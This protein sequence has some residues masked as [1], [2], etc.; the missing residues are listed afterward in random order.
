MSNP[1]RNRPPHTFWKAGVSDCAASG[2]DPVTDVPFTLAQN[3]AVATAGSCFAQ[4]ISR[5][6]VAQGFHY[7]VTE[8]YQG[9][10]GTVD[11]NYGVFPA[12]F[13]NL[14]TS[15]QLVQLFDRAYG[16]SQ[17]AVDWWQGKNQEFIDPFRPRI[18]AGGFATAELLLADREQHFAAV[19]AMFEQCQVFIFTLGLTETWM[20]PDGSALPLAPG[21]VANDSQDSAATFVNLGV[22]EIIADLDEFLAKFATVN[23]TAKIILTVSPVSLIATYENRH[24]LVSTIASKSILRAAAEDISKRHAHVAYFPSY[25]IITGPQTA[26]K[27][28]APDLREVTPEGV[29]YVMSI[30]TR[31]FLSSE[32]KIT[33]AA[34][35]TKAPVMA[36]APQK[37]PTPAPAIG[38]TQEMTEQDTARMQEIADIICDEEAIVE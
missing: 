37:L 14:Y 2:V 32:T 18:Q 25:E 26:A 33:N 23:P 9:K 21:V 34:P 17:P 19:R 24:V 10:P 29:A 22:G 20:L 4:H 27:F 30:F 11:E 35:P 8:T 1:Y 36:N 16:L 38:R 28:Y 15:R 3:H 6:L 12:R 31:H 13:A 5:T 7:L